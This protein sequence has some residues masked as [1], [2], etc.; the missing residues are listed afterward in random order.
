MKKQLDVED[1]F[2]AAAVAQ[3]FNRDQYDDAYVVDFLRKGRYPEYMIEAVLEL[4]KRVTSEE[5]DLS[6]SPDDT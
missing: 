1:S 3:K 4:R 5:K 2:L 6:R